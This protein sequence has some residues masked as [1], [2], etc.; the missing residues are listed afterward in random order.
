MHALI[1]NNIITALRGMVLACGIDP[2]HPQLK[3]G[4]GNRS[5]Y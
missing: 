1:E 5:Y 3:K 4:Q 2:T